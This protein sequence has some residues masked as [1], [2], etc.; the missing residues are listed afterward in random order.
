MSPAP[1]IPLDT[2][3]HQLTALG[4]EH[5]ATALP[6]LVETATR[7][8]LDAT[9][10]LGRILTRQLEGGGSGYQRCRGGLGSG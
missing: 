1:V 6:E 3:A 4:L 7:E 8:R 5:A 2:L 10:L 9:A